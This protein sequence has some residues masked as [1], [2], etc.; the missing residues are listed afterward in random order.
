MYYLRTKAAAN[1]IQF[2]IN[3]EILAQANEEESQ[4]SPKSGQPKTAAAA[5]G[6]DNQTSLAQ[7]R[8]VPALVKGHRSKLLWGGGFCTGL[9]F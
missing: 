9:K 1:A 5:D 3:K 6:G 7:V 8:P 2:T 4:T